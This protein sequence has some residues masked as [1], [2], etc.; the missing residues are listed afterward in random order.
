MGAVARAIATTLFIAALCWAIGRTNS[1]FWLTLW[2][3]LLFF[4]GVP[5]A[6]LSLRD[7]FYGFAKRKRF[8]RSQV[9]LHTCALFA[10]VLGYFVG[11]MAVQSEH[12]KAHLHQL[13]V[14]VFPL[15]VY[16]APL[17]M[18][19]HGAPLS[20]I[21]EFYIRPESDDDD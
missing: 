2:F 4:I 3:I 21:K 18:V 1:E 20:R 16:V 5:L 6:L 7:L 13:M 9:L 11:V 14:V 15:L 17:L 8:G 19:L 12:P 10:A